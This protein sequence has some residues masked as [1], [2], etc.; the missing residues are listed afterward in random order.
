MPSRDYEAERRARLEEAENDPGWT[1][2]RSNAGSGRA[3][4]FDEASADIPIWGWLSGAAARRDAAR[5]AAERASQEAS[6]MDL[7]RNAPDAAAL[8]PDYYLEGATD[9]FGNLLGDPSALIGAGA[10]DAAAQ[11]YTMEALRQLYE[12]GGYT[13]ADR[14]AQAAARA[15]QAQQV[16]AMNRAALA[17]MEAR[18]MGGSGA[19]LATQLGGSQALANANQQSDAA[20]Q[21]AAMQRGL[22]ALQGYGG[23]ATT[24]RG[25]DLTQ[26]SALDAFNQANM[27]WRRDRESRNT[28][29]ANRQ[30]DANVSGRQ[31][32]WENQANAQ[33]GR[34]GNWQRSSAERSRDQART[35]Q[36]NETGANVIGTLISELL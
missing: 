20:L 16:G 17:Q 26:A 34:E 35:D 4:D 25:Q 21:M 36:A 27:A 1:R 10:D 2:T 9:E 12:S 13:P 19:A 28:V 11:Q 3:S 33:A 23:M 18:G 6:W 7:Q 5:A 32:A 31:R 14:A 8:T 15:A 30:Q 29:W 22:A 24:A